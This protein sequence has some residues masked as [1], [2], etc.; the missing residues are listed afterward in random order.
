MLKLVNV[1]NRY[2]FVTF[3]CTS[4]LLGIYSKPPPPPPLAFLTY[5]HDTS[6][7]RGVVHGA[8]VPTPMSELVLALSDPHLGALTDVLHVVLVELAQLLLARRQTRQLAA[9][10]LGADD[11]GLWEQRVH[12]QR[13]AEKDGGDTE[14]SVFTHVP[15]KL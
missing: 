6:K 12:G 7:N 3:V 15:L 5:L 13:P 8:A 14:C 11:V 1:V 2:N 9:Q 10:R 4:A